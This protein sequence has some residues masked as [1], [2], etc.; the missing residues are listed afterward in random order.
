MS[1]ETMAFGGRENP[2]FKLFESF[3]EIKKKF[4]A[5][6]EEEAL[7]K[8]VEMEAKKSPLNQNEANRLRVQLAC[9][10]L[11]NQRDP[12]KADGIAAGIVDDKEGFSKYYNEMREKFTSGSYEI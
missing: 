2:T 3:D 9:F 5:G 11:E 12:Q 8:L 7:L 1:E 4:Q 10:V 6:Q